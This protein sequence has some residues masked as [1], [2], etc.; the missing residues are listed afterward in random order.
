M[1]NRDICSFSFFQEIIR[2]K[3]EFRCCAGGCCWC[4]CSPGCQ[5]EVIVE[6]PPGNVVGSVTQE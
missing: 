4:A 5:Q 1:H 2:I 3:R 6:S